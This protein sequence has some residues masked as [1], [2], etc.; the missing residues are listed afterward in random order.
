MLAIATFYQFF[1]FPDYAEWRSPLLTLC[2]DN[3]LKGTILL[4]REGINGT[5]AGSREGIDA[6]LAYLRSDSRI[7]RLEYKESTAEDY[8]FDRL[9]V[10]LKQEIVTLGQP[11]I[12]PSARVGTYV[13]P[14]DW[15]EL[16]SDPEV[17]VIDT[18]NDYEVEIGSFRGAENPNTHSFRD[19]PDYAKDRLKPQEHRKIAMFC[20]GG[21]RCEKATAFLLEQGFEEVYHLQGGILKYL[22]EVPAQESL[23]E[24]E[25]FVFDGRVSVKQGLEPGS[26]DLCAGCGHP[27][28]EEDKASPHYEAGICCP[29]CYDLL[30]PEKRS[31]QQAKYEQLQLKKTRD[32][33]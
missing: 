24:G 12:D 20:T 22:E 13:R 19:F 4:A 25:C 8:P 32:S 30:T 9:K 5:M 27:I 17:T 10:R 26:Y 23:W 2:N 1:P 6:L 31:R 29:N 11:N 18:R 16:I 21:I 7:D 15:N 3:Q 14:E 28:S 33:K